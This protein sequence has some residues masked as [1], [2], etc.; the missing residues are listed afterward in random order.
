YLRPEYRYRP[1]AIKT[2]CG[3]SPALI[4]SVCAVIM[5]ARSDAKNTTASATSPSVG[6][7]ANGMF[8]VM[9]AMICSG[10]TPCASAVDFTKP[11]TGGP[12][13]QV[14]TTVFTRI[15]SGP[16]SLAKWY[17]AEISAAFEDWYAVWKKPL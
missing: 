3:N 12:H 6:I 4:I 16:S 17:T 13:I 15:L 5:R 14:G 7:S 2:Q 1:V 11:S 10:G 9:P 8:A